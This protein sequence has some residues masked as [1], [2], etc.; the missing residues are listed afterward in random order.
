MPTIYVV[1]EQPNHDISPARKF[2]DIKCILP[3]GDA[4]FSSHHVYNQLHE[5]LEDYQIGEDFLL[6]SGDPTA[7]AMAAV[8]IDRLSAPTDEQELRL[9]KWDRRMREYFITTIPGFGE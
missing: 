3:P 5:A 6:L 4:N 2:G 9:L 7:I 1:Q 8:I